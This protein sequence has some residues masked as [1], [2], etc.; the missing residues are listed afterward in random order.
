MEA[1]TLNNLETKYKNGRLEL[2]KSL[3]RSLEN[4]EDDKAEQT[5][6]EL[7]KS[8]ESY[9][10]REIG[11]LTRELHD[12]LGY[13]RDEKRLAELTRNEIPNA[14][15]RLNYV[16]KKT[17]ESAHK[18]LD[19]IDNLV[20]IS[21]ELAHES[22]MMRADWQRFKRREMKV[23]EFRELS[24]ELEVFLGT[25]CSHAEKIKSDLKDVMVAQDYQDITGQIIW[26]VINLVQEVEDKLVGVIRNASA[27]TGKVSNRL[28][29]VA[30]EGPQIN[31]HDEPDIMSGQDDVDELL[32]SLGF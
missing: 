27:D 12:A 26:K 21:E 3:V 4:G 2:A 28:K 11:K 32:S 15:D 30:A 8:Y 13:C 14:R 25:A 20:P 23:E 29:T 24:A 5:I 31:T 7:T 18:T 17:E 19:I 6:H 22:N 9:I 10:F 16:I 1:A